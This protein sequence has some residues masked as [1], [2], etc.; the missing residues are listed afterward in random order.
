MVY[1]SEWKTG[2]LIGIYETH[3]HPKHSG[4]FPTGASRDYAVVLCS[5]F[6]AVSI[7]TATRDRSLSYV[8]AFISA[9]FSPLKNFHND[10]HVI[11]KGKQP[12][13]LARG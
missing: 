11:W 1:H 4:V 2:Y 10:M 5:V 13:N 12:N 8:C 6:F 3:T 7:L 9:Y